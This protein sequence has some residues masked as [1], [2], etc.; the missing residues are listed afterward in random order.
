MSK[1]SES[2]KELGLALEK[3]RPKF[4][5]NGKYIPDFESDTYVKTFKLSD[6]QK[7]KRKRAKSARKSRK[8]NRKWKK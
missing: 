1:A 6:K 4:D 5:R 3:L 2:V 8:I 7:G